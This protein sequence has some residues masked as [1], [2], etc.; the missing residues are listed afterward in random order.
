VNCTPARF[1]L[2]TKREGQQ[3]SFTSRDTP[4]ASTAVNKKLAKRRPA[5]PRRLEKR[6]REELKRENLL[7]NVAPFQLSNQKQ[8]TPLLTAPL[9]LH[10]TRIDK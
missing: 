9:F 6:G 3:L 7:Y 1:V 4:A 8:L 10:H 2:E 5:N